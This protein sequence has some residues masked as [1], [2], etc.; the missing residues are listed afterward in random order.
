M[1]HRRS[2]DDYRTSQPSLGD[3]LAAQ[4]GVNAAVVT[5]K[6]VT[7]QKFPPRQEGG[8]ERLALVIRTEEYPDNAYFPSAGKGGPIDRLFD[9]LGDDTDR[10]A[11]E[12]IPLV[13]VRDVTNPSTGTKADK[14]HV[15]PTDEWDDI[16]EQFAPKA[17]GKGRG[18]RK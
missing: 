10:W 6:E 12:K 2:P 4:R 9:R 8:K 16:L 14:F 13:R 11:G 15:P 1:A 18:G 3:V 17:K 7:E 5:I